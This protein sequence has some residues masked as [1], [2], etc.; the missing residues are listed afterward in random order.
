[1][2]E[3]I[4]AIITLIINILIFLLILYLIVTKHMS[5][6]GMG[7]YIRNGVAEENQYEDI[8][9]ITRDTI[10]NAIDFVITMTN[11]KSK[12]GEIAKYFQQAI[13]DSTESENCKIYLNKNYGIILNGK[14]RPYTIN[15][16]N[17]LIYI[18]RNHSGQLRL[19]GMDLPTLSILGFYL[20]T[21]TTE[22]EKRTRRVKSKTSVGL[23][24]QGE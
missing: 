19:L 6:R 10:V 4:V 12:P 15:C 17:D 18:K 9:K 3:N 8:D 21:R 24:K 22:P 7:K 20:Y 2:V 11:N 5:K 16:I 14:L 23:K 1:M 13:L